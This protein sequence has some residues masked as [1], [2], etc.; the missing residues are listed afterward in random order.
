M[1]VCCLS[2]SLRDFVMEAPAD[3]GGDPGPLSFPMEVNRPLLSVLLRPF[4]HLQNRTKRTKNTIN[5]SLEAVF[6][7]ISCLS[8]LRVEQRRLC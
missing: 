1:N 4:L 5:Y 6:Q 8:F 2:P 3:E 7:A